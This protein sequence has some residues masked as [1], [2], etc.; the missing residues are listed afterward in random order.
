[1]ARQ[2]RINIPDAYYHVMSRGINGAEIFGDDEDRNK[3]LK[4][5]EEALTK[6][7]SQ[8]HAWALMSNHIH[9]LV[10]TTQKPLS[11]LMQQ[12]LAQYAVYFNKKYK[13]R[14]YLFQG[15][16][17]SILCQKD[18]YFIELVKYIHLNPIRA[19]IIASV[20]ELHEYPWTGHSAICGKRKRQ[21]QSK[22]EILERFG[23]ER[24]TAVKKYCVYIEDGI[25]EEKEAGS[26]NTL[27]RSFRWWQEGIDG[28]CQ[29]DEKI[30]GD[31]KFIE[32]VLEKAKEN[33]EKETKQKYS[34]W[35]IEKLAL[36]TCLELG[37]SKE[38][39]REKG[40]ENKLWS[41]QYLRCKFV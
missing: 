18:P 38:K 13:R 2:I 5:L 4:C 27:R 40:R 29:G 8:C 14:G 30:L 28:K 3:I 9:L 25:G 19:K 10:K 22:R 7:S 6:T 1:M 17:K 31:P 21:W 16:Y 41:C 23:N 36:K 12:F 26:K 11:K 20:E 33:I 24:D 34:G 39:I 32:N 37:V 35:D 15:R